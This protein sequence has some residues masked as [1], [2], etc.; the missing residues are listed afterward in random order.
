LALVQASTPTA[1][2]REPD[3]LDFGDEDAVG[4]QHELAPPPAR[5][6]RE[7]RSTGGKS[8]RRPD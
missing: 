2:T 4:L 7:R 3:E 1:A 6:R 8:D 5:P